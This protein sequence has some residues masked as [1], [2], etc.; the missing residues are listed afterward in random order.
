[1]ENKTIIPTETASDES[2]HALQE[3][4]IALDQW[5][6]DMIEQKNEPDF[7]WIY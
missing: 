2:I 4:D 6:I 3:Q 1:M 5:V 7:W